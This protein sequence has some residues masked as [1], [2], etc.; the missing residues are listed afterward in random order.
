MAVEI[1]GLLELIARLDKLGGDV[2]EAIEKGTRGA[3]RIVNDAAKMSC[4]VDT[5]Q[6]RESLHTDYRREGNV[7]IGAVVTNVE[8]AAYVEFG[9][10]PVG[11]GTYPYPVQG[12]RYKADPWLGKIPEVGL[13]MIHGQK[14]Q[15]FLYPALINSR[16][17]ILYR[18]NMVLK[19][20]IAILEAF[21]E[22][23]EMND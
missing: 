5:G 2:D 12:L 23:A 19:R 3:A 20:T 1:E 17:A 22:E 11:N 10:G 7:H 16:S 14:A 18:Y 15:P 4:P 21:S 9:T 8:H 6:L 13:R